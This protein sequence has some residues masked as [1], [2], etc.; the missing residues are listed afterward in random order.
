[1]AKENWNPL[2][3]DEFNQK[4]DEWADSR[5]ALRGDKA[6]PHTCGNVPNPWGPPRAVGSNQFYTTFNEL[7]TKDLIRHFCDAIGDKN[8]LFRWEEYAKFTQYG[9]IIAPP[10]ILICI[11]EAG[12]GM[13][14]VAPGFGRSLAGGSTWH[15]EKVIRPGDS[16]HVMGTDLGVNEKFPHEPKPYRLFQSVYRTTYFNQNNELVA[17][18]DRTRMNIV[19]ETRDSTEKAFQNHPRHKYTQ[20]ELDAIHQ[21]YKDQYANIRGAKTRFWEDVEIGEE[22]FPLVAGPLNV[23]DATCIMG[24]MGQQAAFDINWDML[25]GNVASHGWV[26]PETNAPRWRAEGHLNDEAGRQTGLLAGAYGYHGQSEAL[27]QRCVLNWMGDDGFLKLQE[28]RTRRPNWHGDTTWVKGHVIDKRIEN[29]E[30]LVEIDM[31]CENQ[32]GTIHQTSRAIVRLPARA[33]ATVPGK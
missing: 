9:G 18:R 26:D 10:G 8:P 22:L 24:A 30:Y 1:M 5:N 29:D 33:Q 11:G 3:S 32:D 12:A 21:G 17:Y 2:L 28:C 15:F 23:L 6:F 13:G 19:A 31:H 14:K 7:V 20:E 25:D 16:F 27:M 4:V